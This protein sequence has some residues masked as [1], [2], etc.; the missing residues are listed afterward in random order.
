MIMF[1]HN[2]DVTFFM[3]AVMRDIIPNVSNKVAASQLDKM[4]Q[5]YLTMQK[6]EP[7]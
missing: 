5:Y 7:K 1:M 4:L 2:Y 6:Q 3:S